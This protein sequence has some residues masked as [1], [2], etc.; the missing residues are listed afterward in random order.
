MHVSEQSLP[1]PNLGFKPQDMSREQ[2]AGFNIQTY[3]TIWL[4]CFKEAM[5]TS[6]CVGEGE[7]F[8]LLLEIV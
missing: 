4:L 1:N 6:K 2:W 7:L 3:R 5:L 8:G